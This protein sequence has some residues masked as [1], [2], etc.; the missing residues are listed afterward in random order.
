VVLTRGIPDEAT[1]RRLIAD[2]SRIVWT[3]A[4]G[5]TV[6]EAGR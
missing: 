5:P 3:H 2:I 1:A 6:G 4:T